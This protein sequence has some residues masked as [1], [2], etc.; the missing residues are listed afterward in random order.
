MQAEYVLLLF[1]FTNL[2]I[3]VIYI[4]IYIYDLIL[5]NPIVSSFQVFFNY[6]ISLKKKSH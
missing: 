5:N 4:Y 1:S 6:P 3:V 2:I